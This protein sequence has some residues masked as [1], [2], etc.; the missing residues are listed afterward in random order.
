MQAVWLNPM[1]N[2]RCLS[3]K[4]QS[5]PLELN[6][7]QTYLITFFPIMGIAILLTVGSLNGGLLEE[8]STASDRHYHNFNFQLKQ[9]EG[10]KYSLF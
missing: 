6:I 1:D 2:R 9:Q 7:F 4:S 10:A 3:E 8:C 5:R